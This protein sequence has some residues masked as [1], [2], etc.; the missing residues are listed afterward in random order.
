VFFD[1]PRPPL[2]R[3]AFARRIATHGIVLDRRTQLLYDDDALYAN[4][5]PCA[6]PTEGRSSLS[7]LANSRELGASACAALPVPALALVHDW[8]RHGFLAPAR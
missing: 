1:P 6:W 5:E 4:G 8:Y 3:A 7:R 2:S